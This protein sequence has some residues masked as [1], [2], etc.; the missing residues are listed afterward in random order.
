MAWVGDFSKINYA[1]NDSND[2]DGFKP[3]ALINR[4]Y[5]ALSLSPVRVKCDGMGIGTHR[6]KSINLF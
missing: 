3:I 1:T 5:R 2:F 4:P 6:E